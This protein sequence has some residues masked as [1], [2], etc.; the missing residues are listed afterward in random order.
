MRP[1]DPNALLREAEQAFASGQVDVARRA[2]AEALRL[3]GPHPAILHLSALTERRAGDNDAARRNFVEALRLAP[4]DSQIHGNFANFLASLGED[5]QALAHYDEAIEG[6]QP[7]AEL[8]L[9][10]AN[11]LQRLG[12]IDEALADHDAFIAARSGD[13]RGYS[14]RGALLLQIGR[15]TEARDS[16]DFAL[17]LDPQRPVAL[18]GRARA[19]MEL[20]DA[21]ASDF[22]RR[23]LATSPESLD[24]ALGLAE[25]MEAEGDAPAALTLLRERVAAAPG[26]I[27]GQRTLA[28]MAWEA[29]DRATFTAAMESALA[30]PANHELLWLTLATTLAGVDRFADAAD[31]ATRGLASHPDSG[32]LKLLRAA[33]LSD[34]GNREAAERQFAALPADLPGRALME[35][36]HALAAHDPARAD[37]LLIRAREEEPW[38]VAAWAYTALTWR[39][40]G[41]ERALWLTAQ[42]GLVRAL[43]LDLDDGEIAQIAERLRSLHKTR[44]HPVGQSLR[45]GTQTRGNLFARQEPEVRLLADRICEA[46]D[47]YWDELPP[48]DPAHPLLRHRD[49]RPRFAGSWSVRL[50]DGGFHVAHFHSRGLLSSATYLAVPPAAAAHDGWLE[51]G[52][53]PAELG[54]DVQPLVRIEPEP[55]RLA[56]FPSYLFHGTRPFPSGERLSAAFDVVTG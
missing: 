16:F 8:R 54:L 36:R 44:A 55:A 5:E 14:A 23:A 37:H 35:A 34:S 11:L 4:H 30:G 38:N 41:D 22:Y 19:A 13:P 24:I 6:T 51:I 15:L 17:S 43:Q 18:H 26:W 1:G 45:G 33:Y 31:A 39:L 12:R 29:G 52:G 21:D 47:M 40:L 48:L 28:R 46:V 32:A 56:L 25:A 7:V 10:R 50:T 27:D 9:N 20:G 2:L 53:A 42:P 49:S 3:A